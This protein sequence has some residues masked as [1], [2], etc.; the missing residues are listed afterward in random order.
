MR[1]DKLVDCDDMHFGN[2]DTQAGDNVDETC[3]VLGALHIPC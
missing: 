1:Q 3:L 2:D